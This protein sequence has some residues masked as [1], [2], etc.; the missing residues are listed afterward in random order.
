M[1]NKRLERRRHKLVHTITE[2]FILFLTMY[3][4]RSPRPRPLKRIAR[5]VSKAIGGL[6]EGIISIVI[7][8]IVII[9]NIAEIV[10]LLK[11]GRKRKKPENLILS[12]SWADFFV[13]L[14]YI[15][16]GAAKIM[17]DYNPRSRTLIKVTKTTR[18]VF[19]FTIVVSV[20]HLLV[21]TVERLYAV[22]RPFQYRTVV[23]MKRMIFII[24]AIW[25]C[26]LT[27]IALL[28]FLP[29]LLTLPKEKIQPYLGWLIFVTATV[30]I[31]VYGYLGYTLFNGF[32]TKL[33]K[34][35][36]DETSK[37]N[38]YADQK[39]DTIFY[40]C[41]VAA[42]TLCSFLS[43]TGWLLPKGVDRKAKDLVNTIG[44]FLLV[45]NSFIN[46]I[47]YF[48][49]SHLSRKGRMPTRPL[50]MIKWALEAGTDSKPPTPQV[51]N[52]NADTKAAISLSKT[53]IPVSTP[54]S[55]RQNSLEKSL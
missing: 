25:I 4:A 33:S 21:I 6:T 1:A 22:T 40:I 17:L 55:S 39:R 42:F 30:M 9:L 7:G 24:L 36:S 43:A 3:M 50:E 19:T 27:V 18:L 51:S 16:F 35:G 13:G 31:L 45:S 5:F 28:A 2:I 44:L 32:Q 34:G 38:L 48:W 12:L 15:I 10:V 53:S 49:K 29:R 46:P 23:T 20:L 41:I 54:L 11:K 47:L 52:I 26:S 8:I 37:K 14:V